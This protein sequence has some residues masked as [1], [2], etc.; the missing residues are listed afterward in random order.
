MTEQ[1]Y[2]QWR[3]ELPPIVWGLDCD[4]T[5]IAVIALQAGIIRWV[6][7][8]KASPHNPNADERVHDLVAA[9]ESQLFDAPSIKADLPK[10][11]AI[12]EPNYPRNAKTQRLLCNL[13]GQVQATANRYARTRLIHNSQWK[14]DLLPDLKVKDHTK[15]ADQKQLVREEVN[16]RYRGT[17]DLSQDL[18][19][20]VGVALY[21]EKNMSLMFHYCPECGQDWDRLL[22]A[23]RCWMTHTPDLFETV[24]R[25][26]ISVRMRV[27]GPRI[28]QIM[29]EMGIETRKKYTYNKR[30][31]GE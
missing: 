12:E 17:V 16:R 25:D 15:R 7:E 14:Y 30:K 22:D 26:E 24:S 6:C 8:L 29:R 19:D 23:I 20:A 1:A 11:V 21:A 10:L 27:S 18:I 9:L 13:V 28:S 2:E 3:M 4:T 5:K 31:D